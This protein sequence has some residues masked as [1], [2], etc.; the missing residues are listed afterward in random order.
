MKRSISRAIESL[1]DPDP[2]VVWEAAKDL[3]RAGAEESVPALVKIVKSRCPEVRRLAA[4]WA[5]GHLRPLSA[6][7][8]LIAILNT[9]SETPNIRGQA[10]ESLGYIGSLVDRPDLR[11]A[12]L[13]NLRDSSPDVAYWSAFALRTVGEKSAIPKLRKLTQSTAL[14]SDQQSV[15]MEAKEAI[16]QINSRR[17]KRNP[18]STR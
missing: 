5:L 11:S 8:P 17:E 9:T 15:A 7:S 2:V 10:A 18:R 1:H 14:T 13:R 3:V 4:I 6:I 16:K 12:L